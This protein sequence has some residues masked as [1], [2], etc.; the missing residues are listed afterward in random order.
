MVKAIIVAAGKGE[1]MG[2]GP[3]KQYADLGGMPVVARTLAAFDAC[4]AVDGM[5]LVVP[6]SE[7]EY[8]QKNV[9]LPL[10]C[11]KP[12]SITGGGAQR[13]ESVRNG[14]VAAGKDTRIVLIHDGVRPFV[15][16]ALIRAC[17]QAARE[18]G[19]CIAATQAHDTL[20]STDGS[21]RVTGTLDRKNIW[22]AQTPQA[23]AYEL[24]VL[25]HERAATEG[26]YGTDDAQLVERL[27]KTVS[28]VRSCRENFK[29][30]TPDDLAMA[31][32]WLESVHGRP[33]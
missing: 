6:G 25:A 30:T 9:V 22:L 20:K 32:A 2:A 7:K 3:K 12:V 18:T 27:G 29:I 19:A 5:V 26:F 16:D 1:R 11:Q 31:R 17:I 28:I 10:Q 14:L 8:C 24:I 4:R 23:F 15:S 33:L 21:G 13:Q